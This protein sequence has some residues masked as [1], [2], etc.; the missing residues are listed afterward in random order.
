MMVATESTAHS[1]READTSQKRQT[2]SHA[3]CR[4]DVFRRLSTTLERRS[5]KERGSMIDTNVQVGTD[6]TLAAE[7]R[8]CEDLFFDLEFA[9][10]DSVST[11]LI[12]KR[13]SSGDPYAFRC[14]ARLGVSGQGAGQGS[15]FS[16]VDLLR[17]Y[18]HAC[19][20]PLATDGAAVCRLFLKLVFADLVRKISN[21]Q[22]GQKFSLE[23]TDPLCGGALAILDGEFDRAQES[24]VRAF[25]DAES[26]TFAFAGMGLLRALDADAAGAFE[27]F[28]SAGPDDED[29]RVLA[30]SFQRECQAVVH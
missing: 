26:R 27:A 13:D 14:F 11:G 8:P 9:D 29:I 15:S 20:R 19:E 10:L 28:N 3:S 18:F 1:G 30:N 12:E 4:Q 2:V 6:S 25:S 7:L 5:L 24:F 21:A 17:D 16:L 22:P 23:R